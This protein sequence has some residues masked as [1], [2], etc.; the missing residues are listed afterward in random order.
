VSFTDPTADAVQPDPGQGGSGAAG[1]P[2]YAEFLNRVPEELRGQ[3]EPVLRDWDGQVTQRFQEASDF[4]RQWEPYVETGI[5]RYDPS[6]VQWA[7]QFYEASQAN[8]EGVKAWYE[9]YAKENGLESAQPPPDPTQGQQQSP[10]QTYDE[11]GQA[12]DTQAIENALKAQLA[13]IT[14]ALEGLTRF[15]QQTEAQ[16]READAERFLAGQLSELREKHPD[17]FADTG[18]YGAEKMI[19][20][21]R[22]HYI[23]SDPLNAVPRAFADYQAIIA[24]VEKNALQEKVN[25]P[26]PAL[27]AGMTNASAEPIKTLSEAREGATAFLQRAMQQQ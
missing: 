5:N 9:A 4:R 26:P 2:P 11:F 7:M 8:P 20:R 23:D 17:A 21:L 18:P 22:E 10:Y 6:A 13:P 19:G 24:Q 15:Q 16:Q 27:S 25:Q 3:V 1:D 12:Q 14:N